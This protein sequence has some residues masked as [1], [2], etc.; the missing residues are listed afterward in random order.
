MQVQGAGTE[1]T[2]AEVTRNESVNS[3]RFSGQ[4]RGWWG[5]G[6]GQRR[7]VFCRMHA[8]HLAASA[9]GHHKLPHLVGRR[10]LSGHPDFNGRSLETK[11]V[12]ELKAEPAFLSH[13]GHCRVTSTTPS[14][15]RQLPELQAQGRGR[16]EGH[17]KKYQE[18]IK[19]CKFIQNDIA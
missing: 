6:L 16:R 1:A 18:K 7:P 12:L 5:G 17:L 9:C 14:P 4:G 8:A 19:C 11:Q 15:W 3:T 10:M 2:A 13:S